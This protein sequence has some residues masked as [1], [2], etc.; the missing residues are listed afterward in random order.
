MLGAVR[1]VIVV[2]VAA[3]SS[4]AM[5]GDVD[6]GRAALAAALKNVKGTLESGVKAGERV[7]RPISAKFVVEDGMLKL[8]L[9]IVKDD[10]I[11]EFNL[12]PAI[13]MINEVVDIA[14]PDKI[15]VAAAQKLAIESATI[16]LFAATESAVKANKGF[17]AISVLPTLSEGR[18]VAMVTL[19]GS[20][21]FRVVAEKVYRFGF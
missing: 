1:W 2:T 11:S 7:G 21:G 6:Q 18:P 14:D 15:K 16:S 8:S 19:L 20:D 5:A 12:Y 17:R 10:G 3:F 9:L 13:G 4:A